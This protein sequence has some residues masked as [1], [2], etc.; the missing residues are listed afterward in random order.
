MTVGL[1]ASSILSGSLPGELQ[2]KPALIA[3]RAALLEASNQEASAVKLV[4]QNQASL[5]ADRQKTKAEKAAISKGILPI[6]ARLQLK[7]YYSFIYYKYIIE[8]AKI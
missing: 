4:M 2:E 5:T 1:Q 6:V 8:T 7:V 3:T